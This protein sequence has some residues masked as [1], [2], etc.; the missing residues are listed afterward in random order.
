MLFNSIEFLF[1]FPIVVTLY[2]ALPHRYRWPLLLIA[3][4]YFYMCWKA[5]YI[6]LLIVS[7]LIDYYAGLQM[8]R[9]TN[10]SKR[11]KFLILSLFSN[12]AILFSFKYFNFFNDSVR[13]LFNQWNIFYNVPVFEVLLPIGISFY[14][15]QTMSYSIDVYLGRM[16]PER[17]LGIFALYV[18][19]FPQLVAGP[20]E[21]ATSL[22]PQFYKLQRLDYERVASG[23][24]LMAW[25]FFKKLV[26][27]DRLAVVVDTVYA[28]PTQFSGPALAVATYFF[29]FQIYC[30]FSGYTDIAI[31]AARVM[32]FRLMENFRQPYFS[33]SIGEFWRRWHISLST[34]FKDYLYFPLGGNRTTRG[35]WYRNLLIVFVVSGLWHGANWTFV[36]WGA[37]HGLYLVAALWTKGLRTKLRQA[38]GLSQWPVFDKALK[39]FIT[40]HLVCF[41][42]IFFRASSMTDALYIVSHLF[43]LPDSGQGFGIPIGSLYE[44]EIAVSAILIMELVHLF[45]NCGYS[46][47]QFIIQRGIWM[48]WAAYYG[49]TFSILLF[50][51]FGSTE[52]IYFQF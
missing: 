24:R 51:K 4:Y 41:A 19:F 17:H 16:K 45:Q 11:K 13:S 35:R 31:G 20:I 1:F 12:L 46:V 14:T 48:R 52:F 3:S 9:T 37:L 36:I 25:G 2:F 40:F 10:Q 22:L 8:G 42:W 49:I 34:W 43:V 15:F 39:V 18:S 30:D 23:L 47:N 28:D 33:Q 50:G 7:T 29:A 26:I 32:G 27:A 38:I 21:R 6:I 5:E 44:L